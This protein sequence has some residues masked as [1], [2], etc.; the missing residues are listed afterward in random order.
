M[1]N[2][3]QRARALA[4]GRYRSWAGRTRPAGGSEYPCGRLPVAARP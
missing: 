3:P 1:R 4:H 2:A